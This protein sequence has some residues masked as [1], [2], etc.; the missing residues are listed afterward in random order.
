MLTRVRGGDARSVY[1]RGMSDFRVR[2]EKGRG[3]Y[4]DEEW[5]RNGCCSIFFFFFLFFVEVATCLCRT[6][7]NQKN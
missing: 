3:V 6:M 4:R 5:I 1:V 2:G 7:G